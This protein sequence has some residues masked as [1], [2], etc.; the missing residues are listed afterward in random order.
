MTLT[1]VFKLDTN[2]DLDFSTG[3]IQVIDGVDSLAQRIQTRLNTF[4]GECFLDP[5]TG[6]PWISQVFT[7]SLPT[8]S[9][10]NAAIVSSLSTV[11][12]ILEI[13]ALDYTFD[14]RTR[15]LDISLQ[16]LSETNETLTINTGSVV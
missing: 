9:A 13:V 15:K 16:I 12:G 14:R 11:D 6:T 3:N 8:T 7:S 1:K 10:L 2:N 5:S 4:R